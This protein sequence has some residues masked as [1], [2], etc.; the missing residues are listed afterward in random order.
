MEP[1]LVLTAVFVATPPVVAIS[2]PVKNQR[3]AAPVFDG[4]AHRH[5]PIANVVCALDG[6]NHI[7]TLTAGSGSVS[8]WSIA[9]VPSP[10]MNTFTA[11]AEDIHGIASPSVS[12]SFLF[13]APAVLIVT[14]AG[15]GT[16]AFRGSSSIAGDAVPANGA[17]LNIGESYTITASPGKSS[18]FSNW[19]SVVEGGAPTPSASPILR[20]VMQS[21]LVLTATFIPNFFPVVTGTYN[22]LFYPPGGVTEETSGMLYNLALRDTGSFSGQIL[23]TTTNY[24]FATNFDA[25]GNAE[26]KIGS[27][28]VALKLE[29]TASEIIGTVSSRQFLANLTADLASNVLQPASY[30]ILFSPTKDVSPVS[31]T[32]EGYALIANKSGAVTLSGALADGTAYS[33]VVPVSQ[34]CD[35]PVYAS[36]YTKAAGANT[37]L[38]LGWINLTNLQ[39][40]AP[41][42][43]LAWIKKPLRLPNLYTNGFTNLLSVQ[44]GVW[45]VPPPHSP[46]ISLTNGQLIISNASLVLD[47]TNVVVHDDNSLTSLAAEPTNSLSGSINPQTGRVTVTIANDDG[48]I[49]TNYGAVVQTTTNGGGY[50][51]TATNGGSMILEP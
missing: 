14:N 41:T 43:V 23:T 4:A 22:G 17:M 36:L 1:N 8:N 3:T 26:F 11:H 32:G 34:N 10:G 5:F 27:L 35:V 12:H 45:S 38:L 28:R 48:G 7:A 6:T 40:T 37:G 9:L 16:G 46:A 31:P 50:F 18:L 33:Q 13:K 39:A 30:T 19:T 24:H 15:L 51:L 42:N 20:F 44:G 49:I 21:N 29:M 25:A 47:F 2:S